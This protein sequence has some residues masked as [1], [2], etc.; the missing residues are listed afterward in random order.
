MPGGKATTGEPLERE[1]ASAVTR[2][3][4]IMASALVIGAILTLI[5]TQQMSEH[6][7]RERVLGHEAKRLRRQEA[8]LSTQLRLSSVRS[9]TWFE[10]AGV[11]NQILRKISAP[12]PARVAAA[13]DG[14]TDKLADIDQLLAR[15]DKLIDDARAAADADVRKATKDKGKMAARKQDDASEYMQ[16]YRAALAQYRKAYADA[17]VLQTRIEALTTEARQLRES[18]QSLPTPFGQFDVSPR[19]GLVGVLLGIIGAYLYFVSVALRARRIATI[20]A[21]H[22]PEVAIT[23]GLPAPDWL[24]TLGDDDLAR[25]LG[26]RGNHRSRRARGA[27]AHLVWIAL[28]AYLF[29]EILRW[30]AWEDVLVAP[31]LF[32]IVLTVLAALGSIGVA[33]L[34]LSGSAET[35]YSRMPFNGGRRHFIAAAGTATGAA[36]MLL[37]LR[38]RRLPR[39]KS[40]AVPRVLAGELGKLPPSLVA[41]AKTRV[42]HHVAVCANHFPQPAERSAVRP[43]DALHAHCSVAILTAMIHEVAGD[44]R[45]LV[46]IALRLSP[47]SIHL[48]DVLIRMDGMAQNFTKETRAVVHGALQ[49]VRNELQVARAEHERVQHTKTRKTVMRLEL[50]AMQFE[51]RARKLERELWP[52]KLAKR[53]RRQSREMELRAGYVSG[54]LR[55]PV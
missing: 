22:E 37:A 30:R 21:A 49:R 31:Q 40:A 8:V 24:A 16:I 13:R 27:A 36:L 10:R 55:R 1:F 2:G 4:T 28:A 7:G 5:I 9:A 33:A 19:V 43:T 44:I 26:W 14:R 20:Y 12:L 6:E 15:L 3:Q 54:R 11:K 23:R 47:S 18:K 52:R 46:S 50:L 25:T 48:Y 45:P 41:N 32:I 35:F 42:V 38:V 39:R 51:E 17:S 53:Y 34:F 29:I